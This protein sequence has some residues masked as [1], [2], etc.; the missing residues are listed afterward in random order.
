[1]PTVVID[2]ERLKNIHCGLGQ[3]SLHL[4]RAILDAAG[5]DFKPM[6]LLRPEQQAYYADRSTR[7]VNVST[8]RRTPLAPLTRS[9]LRPISSRESCDLW[10]ATH[11]DVK[12]LPLDDRTPLL[13]TIH[14]LNVL[15]E[16]KPATIRRRLKA[17]QGKVDRATALTTATQFAADE[18]RQHLDVGDKEIAI[19]GHGVCIEPATNRLSRPTF[20][21]PGEFLFTIGDITP[22]KN[23]HVLVDFLK[24]LVETAKSNSR[25]VIAGV[26]E[27]DYAS[28]IQRAA[29]AAGMADRIILPG[30]VSDDDGSWLYDNCEAFLFPS[31]SEG[32]GLPVIEAMSCGYPVF[33]SRATSLPEVG[34]PLAFYWDDFS[35]DSMAQVFDA[36]MSIF[37]HDSQYQQKLR[38]HASQFTWKRSAEA[39]LSLYGR[40]LEITHGGETAAVA[41]P[42]LIRRV[43]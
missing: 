19:I 5:P 16:K 30:A 25:L 6:M 1:M 29:Q 22:K 43:G 33:L 40:I 42:Q 27:S 31:L 17:L 13:L 24:H 4:S 38:Q 36:G 2:V 32:F 28:A 10:H 9:L 15:R 23:F 41:N 14:D 26:N 35:P 21:P 37:R 12:C 7:F 3:F 8:W 34:G 18:I 39:Y 20:L 11:Q